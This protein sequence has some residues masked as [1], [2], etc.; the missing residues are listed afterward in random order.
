MDKKLAKL[1]IE[2]GRKTVRPEAAFAMLGV[3]RSL[4]YN[5]IR[6]GRLRAVRAGSKFLVPITAIDDFL[7]GNLAGNANGK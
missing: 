2:E 3:G 4:G 7:A 6:E 5:L 1:A